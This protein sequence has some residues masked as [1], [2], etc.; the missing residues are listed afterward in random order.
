MFGEEEDTVTVKGQKVP[1]HLSESEADTH[2]M[3]ALILDN[4]EQSTA[5]LVAA[6]HQPVSIETDA[7]VKD[8]GSLD[9][10]PENLAIWIDPI[11]EK[12]F[13]CAWCQFV[14]FKP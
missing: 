9:I 6:V 4:N 8:I 14:F 13:A 11:G 1:I 5:A 2:K 3:L 7:R 10:N 12:V